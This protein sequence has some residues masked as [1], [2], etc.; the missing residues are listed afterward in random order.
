MSEEEKTIGAE[1]AELAAEANE[2]I[3][4]PES[5][6]EEAKE[7]EA[8]V[9]PSEEPKAE[10]K[11]EIQPE[12]PIVPF[13]KHP[14]WKRLEQELAEAREEA[15]LAKEA[16]A[17]KK[18]ETPGV[19]SVP[20]EFQSLFGEDVEAFKAWEGM[21]DARITSK[22]QEIL[23]S[24]QKALLEEQ[25]REETAKQQAV[26]WAEEQFA[27]MA[28]DTGIDFT[29]QSSTER[30]QVLDIVLKYGLF[31]SQGRPKV[32]EAAEIRNAIYSVEDKSNL[33]ERKKIVAKT[34]TKT[35]VLPQEDSVLTSSKLQK[36]DIS[37]FFK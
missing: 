23:E 2:G 27:E 33:S 37:Q 13:H 1:L 34:T 9:S 8:P 10:E 5:Q 15:R 19:Q 4:A 18:E 12:K 30:N 29:D 20:S 22:A 11:P 35:N 3:A 26:S 14:R 7:E 17:Q 36:M 21:L 31:D 24:R 16:I 32:R 6:P 28:D 25:Q